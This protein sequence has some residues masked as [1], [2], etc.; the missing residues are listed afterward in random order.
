CTDT[1]RDSV[2][3]VPLPKA[4]FTATTECLWDTTRFTN[5]STVSNDT[6]LYEWHFGDGG[7]SNEKNPV[8]VYNVPGVF[9]V[10]LK[11]TTSFGYTDMFSSSVY[12]NPN[13]VADFS[14]TNT[15]D[16]V[17]AVFDNTSTISSGTLSYIWTFGPG[18]TS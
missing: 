5:T 3:I 8:H 7:V 17:A 13:P 18:K 9:N 10:S 2:L 1:L 6:L 15:C 4:G 12:I 11:I 16:T 14:T